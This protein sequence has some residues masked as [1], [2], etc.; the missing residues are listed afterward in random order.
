MFIGHTI[1][2]CRENGYTLERRL[3]IV[4]QELR[5]SYR[6]ED[7]KRIGWIPGSNHAADVLTKEI[8]TTKT[9]V[10]NMMKD[11]EVELEPI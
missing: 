8:L 7:V 5:D 1:S 11:N 9:A 3:Q 4:V 2:Q 6:K 10:S